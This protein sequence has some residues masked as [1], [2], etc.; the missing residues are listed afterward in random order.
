[1]K[2]KGYDLIYTGIQGVSDLDGLLAGLVASELDAPSINVV[3]R[4]DPQ[5]PGK[6]SVFKEFAGGVLAEYEVE[7]PVVLGV[8]TSREPPAYIPISKIKKIASE[9][10]IEK[11]NVP[12]ADVTKTT[13]SA[14]SL[15][16]STSHAKMITGKM[17]EQNDKLVTLLKEKG[18]I[19]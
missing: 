7:T 19:S 13:V 8:Q 9:S 16:E 4:V 3:N 5:G 14:Y 18:V 1:M 15:P 12:L 10:K 2:G 11:I 17:N 6:V